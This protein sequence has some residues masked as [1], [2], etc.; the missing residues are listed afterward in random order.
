MLC[1][2]YVEVCNFKHTNIS[3]LSQGE[4]IDIEGAIQELDEKAPCIIGFRLTRLEAMDFKILI[5]NNNIISIPSM[6]TTLHY[7]FTTYYVFN[8]TFPLQYHLIL[9]FLEKY[10][11]DIKPS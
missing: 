10:V 1:V 5:K 8:I 2:Y 3:L 4:S 11:Y 6:R 7:Y 9:L